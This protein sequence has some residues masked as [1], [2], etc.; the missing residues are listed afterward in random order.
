MT[1]WEVRTFIEFINCEKLY[2]RKCTI[3]CA[4]EHLLCDIKNKIT[5]LEQYLYVQ[6]PKLITECTAC[7]YRKGCVTEYVCHTTSF[8]SAKS[9]FTTEKLLSARMVRNIP[10]EEL[11]NEKRNAAQ[12][13]AG[14]FGYVMFTWVNCQAGDRLVN[15]RKLGRFP[16]AEDLS[17]HFQPGVHFYF[18]YNHL[19]KH[20]SVV[21]D[22]VLPCKIKDE[23]IL[24]D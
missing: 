4:D 8:E 12:N 22:G 15:E 20:P 3:E 16:N 13:P 9:I 6:R 11:M 18:K 19:I 7:P 2:G 10:V 5:K 23:V 14:Y 24:M 21:F 17:T 1:D